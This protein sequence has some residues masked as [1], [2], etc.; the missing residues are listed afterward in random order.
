MVDSFRISSGGLRF[1]HDT[2][3]VDRFFEGDAD[4]GTAVVMQLVNDSPTTTKMVFDEFAAADDFTF[5]KTVVPVRLARLEGEKL[6]S[7]PQAKR[8]LG[9]SEKFRT[10][11]LDFAG[12]SEIS[13]AFAD[14]IF[15]VFALTTPQVTLIPM[16]TTAPVKQ[17]ISRAQKSN[18]G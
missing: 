18:V 2:E 16:N 6:V 3:S 10:V 17:M 4:P 12:V 13:Q 7:R 5:D 8:L 1:T 9:R 15:R 11:V 14:E